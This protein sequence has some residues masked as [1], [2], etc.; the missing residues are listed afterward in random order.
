MA[1]A[2]S[3]EP[4]ASII[5]STSG[6][7][8][9]RAAFTLRTQLAI[10][11][12]GQD[13]DAA[14]AAAAALRKENEELRQLLQQQILKPDASPATDAELR[15]ENEQ[16]RQLV[17]EFEQRLTAEEMQLE[18]RSRIVSLPRKEDTIRGYAHVTLMV[19]DEAARVP[20]DLYRAVRPMLAVSRGRLICL[21]KER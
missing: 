7:S 13:G 15:S 20:D 3:S 18:N 17:A 1:V 4:C 2:T 19:I 8:P 10:L 16:L 9:R 12:H 11:E 6:P 21:S 14:A 5:S